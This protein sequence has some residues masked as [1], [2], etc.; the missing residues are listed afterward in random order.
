MGIAVGRGTGRGGMG[1]TPAP[2]TIKALVAVMTVYDWIVA[3]SCG[4]ISW[5]VVFAIVF[6]DCAAA[7]S[8]GGI[9]WAA[10]MMVCDCAAAGSC[11]R[12]SWACRKV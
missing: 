8:C 12:I 4:G 6:C 10:V 1:G 3:G 5:A 2:G 7:G 9:S 11:G